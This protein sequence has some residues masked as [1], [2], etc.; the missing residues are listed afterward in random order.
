MAT[1]IEP[2]SLPKKAAASKAQKPV[3]TEIAIP[4]AVKDVLNN[5]Q[6]ESFAQLVAAGHSQADAYAQVYGGDSVAVRQNASRLALREEV[7]ERIAQIQRS[8]ATGKYLT[9][10]KKREF[11][12]DVVMTPISE[13][14][15]HSILCQAWSE[16]SGEKSYN[17]T[18]KMPDKLRAIE[19]DAKL[20]GELAVQDNDPNGGAF[21][22]TARE[23]NFIAMIVNG[24][25]AK[26]MPNFSALEV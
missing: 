21:P 6:H 3:A 26:T 16:S 12:H 2:I 24:T 22:I 9:I 14:D 8:T 5:A 11:L 10:R 25:P 17:E 4:Q 23:I 20:A 1:K 13:V 18:M 15:R 19:L 7:R